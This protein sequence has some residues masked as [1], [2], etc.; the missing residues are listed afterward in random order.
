M[1]ES[2]A[3]RPRP[4]ASPP[5]AQGSTVSISLHPSDNQAFRIEQHS[6]CQIPLGERHGKAGQL[7]TL[8]FGANLNVLT[9]VI[10]ALATT[11][12]HGPVARAIGG[13]DLSWVAGIAV[14]SPVYYFAVRFSQRPLT[15]QQAGS[16]S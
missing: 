16:V 12:F 14:V 1:L 11:I 15:A 5:A 10:G 4:A 3:F 8:W 7:F 2:L 13:G 9:V 6:I